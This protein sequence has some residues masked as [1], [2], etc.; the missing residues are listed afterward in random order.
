MNDDNAG[1]HQYADLLGH[2]YEYPGR[3]RR[4]IATGEPFVYYRGRTTADG[5]RQPQ[6]YLGVGIVGATHDHG[7]RFRCDI[8]DYRQFI[9]PLPFRDSS[10]TY[11]EPAGLRRNYWRVGVR[12]ID[13]GT[14]ARICSAAAKVKNVGMTNSRPGSPAPT[15]DAGVLN[16]IGSPDTGPSL[17]LSRDRWRGVPGGVCRLVG[18]MVSP[19]C[20]RSA[21]V[22]R[23][24]VPAR[25]VPVLRDRRGG[26]DRVSRA[27]GVP[28]A[29]RGRRRSQTPRASGRAARA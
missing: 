4:M 6:V 12:P 18:L 24:P 9:E 1:R 7:A 27:R 19:G 5:R 26:V 16:Q 25:V 8:L 3:Y 15:T 29:G 20:D 22:A 10:G 28:G 21:A 14:F 13:A 23:A 17:D 11:Y 2:S